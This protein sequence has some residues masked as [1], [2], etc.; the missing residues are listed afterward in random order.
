VAEVRR[1]LSRRQYGLVVGGGAALTALQLFALPRALG[2]RGFGI[3]VIGISVTQAVFALADLGFARLAD[4]ST[5]TTDERNAFRS[6]AMFTTSLVV[7]IGLVVCGVLRLA[8][9]GGVIPAVAA[10][11]AV[12][13]YLL[14]PIQLAAGAA[15]ARG[16]EVGAAT[17]HVVWQNLP[18]VGLV[19]GAVITRTPLGGAVGGL[20]A[21]AALGRP[22]LGSVDHSRRLGKTARALRPA[23]LSSLSAFLISWGGT[24]SIGAVRGLAA[25][26][27]YDFDYRVLSGASYLYY[28]MGSVLT[29]RINVRRR[30]A[31]REVTV[32]TVALVCVSQAAA[33]T[34]VLLFQK[35]VVGIAP[36]GLSVLIVLAGV[37]LLTT[38]SYLMGATLIAYGRLWATVTAAVAAAVVALVGH[39]TITPATGPIGAASVSAASMA[40]AAAMQARS[41]RRAH[42]EIYET[43]GPS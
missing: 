8:H 9:V 43:G 14:T 35:Q 15:E 6:A 42:W 16:D 1:Q 27:R 5:R 17:Y 28:P 24:Y 40:L 4:D 26:G 21:S 38:V 20:L 31:V 11:S 41:A 34:G 7:L 30:E 10:A 13:A 19:L 2:Q 18:K 29:A 12:T 23:W 22:R 37:V 36:L 25:A 3:A 32:R 39:V 33:I